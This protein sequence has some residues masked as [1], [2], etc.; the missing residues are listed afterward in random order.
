VEN[1]SLWSNEDCVNHVALK[2]IKSDVRFMGSVICILKLKFVIS[3]CFALKH[4]GNEMLLQLLKEVFDFLMTKSHYIM[5]HNVCN[6]IL[7]L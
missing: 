7:T 5:T 4:S 3:H 1:Y 6:K 2:Y